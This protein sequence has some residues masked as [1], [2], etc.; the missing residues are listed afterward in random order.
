[1]ADS[2]SHPPAEPAHAHAHSDALHDEAAHV[3]AH[4]KMYL[5]I[6]GA[7]MV[8]TLVTVGLSYIDFGSHSRNVIIGMI[9]AT[10]KASLVAAIFMHLKGERKTIWQVLIFTTIFV[11]GLFF[12]TYLHWGDPIQGTYHNQH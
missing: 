1:M 11:I 10:F 7:L 12:L 6:G 5:V 4:I 3:A 2:H 8:L 9:V